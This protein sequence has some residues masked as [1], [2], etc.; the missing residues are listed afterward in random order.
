MGTQGSNLTYAPPRGVLP[1]K[2][3]A[4]P[5]VEKPKNDYLSATVM[6]APRE[7]LMLML[8]DGAVRATEKGRDVMEIDQGESVRLLARAQDIVAELMTSLRP[9]LGDSY[10]NIVNLYEFAFARIADASARRDSQPL[11]GAI[12]VL[13]GIK[14][15]WAEAVAK[16]N[17]DGR[18][19]DLAAAQSNRFN[20]RA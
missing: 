14:E 12:K 19:A 17:E 15:M 10:G 9:D 4:A 1:A 11:D 7:V 8:I 20:A 2:P 18:P 13:R 16:M 5:R 3:Q 6:T